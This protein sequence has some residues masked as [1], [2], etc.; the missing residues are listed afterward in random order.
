ML[1]SSNVTRWKGEV[2]A[3]TSFTSNLSPWWMRYSGKIQKGYRAMHFLAMYVYINISV[4]IT[5]TIRIH[6]YNSHSLSTRC[7]RSRLVASLWTICTVFVS[8]SCYTEACHR[9]ACS[10][11]LP[12]GHV[13]LVGISCCFRPCYKVLMWLVP[14]LSNN[15]EQAL[16]THLDISLMDWL[17][18]QL[19]CRSVTVFYTH[20]E[21]SIRT[22][23]IY[24]TKET[25]R[26]KH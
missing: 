22:T 6:T 16:R 10:N 8:S 19:A 5:F 15:W 4:L 17:V 26:S 2:L 3:W 20:I 23:C 12:A 18:I 1:L 13:R 24:T 14:D 21:F 11:L 9:Q 25:Q 7:V